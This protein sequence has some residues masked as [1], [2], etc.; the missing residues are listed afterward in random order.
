MKLVAKRIQIWRVYSHMYSKRGRNWSSLFYHL[1]WKHYIIFSPVGTTLV[2]PTFR[3]RTLSEFVR[4]SMHKEE[5]NQTRLLIWNGM[6]QDVEERSWFK[7]D[8]CSY[9]QVEKRI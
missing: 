9:E 6:E 4:I 2:V 5:T 3:K 1:K 8:K 7:C